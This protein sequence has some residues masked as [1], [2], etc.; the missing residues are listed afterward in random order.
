MRAHIATGTRQATVARLAVQF[1]SII[2][3]PV[4]IAI[5]ISFIYVLL[6]WQILVYYLQIDLGQE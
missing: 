3:G 6:A 4:Q 2:F 1:S 5:Y